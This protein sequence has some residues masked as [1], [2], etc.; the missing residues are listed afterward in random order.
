[1]M[2]ALQYSRIHN[3]VGAA[4]IQRRALREALRWAKSRNAFRR[5]LIEF[6]MVRDQLLA[7]RVRFE[8][9]TLLAFEAALTFD[10]VLQNPGQR[11]WLRLVTALAKYLSAEDAIQATR[12]SLELLGGNGYTRDY[13]AERLHR[14]AQVLTVW[15]GPANIQALELLRMLGAKYAGAAEYEQRM[16][17]IS[18]SLPDGVSALR[19]ML[20]SR[21]AEDLRA[22]RSATSDKEFAARYARKLLHRLSQ[23]LAFG[24][25]CEMATHS[26]A[27]GDRRSFLTAWRY[28]EEIE[29]PKLGA[30]NQDVSDAALELLDDET[31]IRT[32]SEISGIASVPSREKAR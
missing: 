27:L 31:G 20:E 7:L 26:E 14:D 23:S 19:P 32:E 22:I 25:M 10:A 11:S 24:L 3:A 8:A 16:R 5:A 17:K 30:E 15:E 12:A 28:F 9:S 18:E 4:G 1:M 21:L 29:P 2:Q 6:P 13:P